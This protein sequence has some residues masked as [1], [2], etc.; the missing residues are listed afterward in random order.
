MNTIPWYESRV[1]QQQIVQLLV[2]AL[3]LFGVASDEINLEDTAGLIFGGITGAVALWT[4]MTR[5]FHPHPPI[6]QSQVDA[7]EARV[8]K[9]AI[10]RKQGGY[11]RNGLV[12]TLL[13]VGL[14]LL[15]TGTVLAVHGC[16]GSGT[17]E[18]Y[19][20]ADNVG[21]QAYVLAEHYATLIEQAAILKAKPTTPL[22]A[23]SKMQEADRVAKPVVLRLKSLRDAYVAT[24]NADTEAQLQLAVNQAVLAVA[25]L[26]RA[27]NTA[28]GGA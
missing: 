24:K 13:V 17:R 8:A 3:T 23:I 15:A 9:E 5:L 22:S 1:L 16:T 10:A 18:A 26:V 21:E 14:A 2:A 11:A 28:R 19:K 27:V 20:Q 12:A 4:F 6:T 25:D 7:T